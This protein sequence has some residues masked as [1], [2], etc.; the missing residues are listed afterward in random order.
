ME[1]EQRDEEQ[2]L[3]IF[4]KAIEEELVT[5]GTLGSSVK[6]NEALWALRENISES[7]APY[8]PYKNDI[9]LRP[10]CITPFLEKMEAL[11]NAHYSEFPVVWFGHLGDGNL[12]INIVKPENQNKTDFVQKCEALNPALFSLVQKFNGT[13]S[14]EH[15]IG[16]LKKPYLHYSRSKEEIHYMKQIKKI[17]D[18][19]NIINPGKNILTVYKYMNLL[20]IRRPTR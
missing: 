6:Q 13:V 12:H 5:D 2:A 8:S 18:P 14:A 19:K 3:S 11:F 16:I 10:S 4:K 15:G 17:F 20:K 7:L 1:V 9:A